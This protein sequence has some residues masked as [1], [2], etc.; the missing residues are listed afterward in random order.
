MKKGLHLPLAFGILVLAISLAIWFG[1]S[2]KDKSVVLGLGGIEKAGTNQEVENHWLSRLEKLGGP[3]AY[4]ELLS[5]YASEPGSVQHTNAH[6]F[7]AALYKEEGLPGVAVCDSNFNF[8]C[9]H[10]FIGWAIR[11]HGLEVAP[12]LNET[13]LSKH[14]SE[15][16]GC[17]HGVGHGVLTSLGYE[18]E[19]LFE[20]LDTCAK[21]RNQPPVGGCYGGV[22]MEF[23]MRTI[24]GDEGRF[25]PMDESLGR[26]YPCSV[27]G[28]SFKAGCYY[29]LP[30][31]WQAVFYEDWETIEG[32]GAM[33]KKMGT[34][35]DSLNSESLER[36]CFLG[37]GTN[38]PAIVSWDL[39]EMKEICQSMPNPSAQALCL[40]SSAASFYG[41]PGPSHGKWSMCEGGSKEEYDTCVA[42]GSSPR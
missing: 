33:Y 6:L 41:V 37:L 21:F 30:Q 17:Q 12:S 7:G 35:C 2:E 25:R 15:A 34:W 16:L 13:C 26:N 4:Q 10:E 1:V 38:A 9:Y 42:I 23:N 22:F 5:T 31:W 39:K 18:K 36:R 27:V 3:R 14:A 40:A 29:E 11:D 32:R 24:L 19:N 20:A 8:G 28:E